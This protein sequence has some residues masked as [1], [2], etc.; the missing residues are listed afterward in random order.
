MAKKKKTQ[1]S[2]PVETYPV[3]EEILTTFI[4]AWFDDDFETAYELLS[5][6]SP[7]REGLDLDE[8]VE[9]RENWAEEAEPV[10]LEPG[11]ISVRQSQQSEIWV[12]SNVS[13]APE[14]K[15][16]EAAWSVE[17]DDTDLDETLPELPQ[18]T[19]VYDETQ[20]H[21]YWATYTLV[22]E[23]G[24]WR[25]ES[26][27]DETANARSL[28]VE[29]LQQ[30]I[31][32][33]D[34]YVNDFQ[35]KYSREA[36][37]EFSEE[38]S[39]YFAGEIFKRLLQAAAYTDALIEKTPLVRELY[40]SAAA[41]MV[42]FDQL[43]RCLVYLEPLT[44]QFE[45]GRAENLR[46]MADVQQMLSEKYAEVGE[47][48]REIR[49]DELAEE[50]LK[51]SLTI[52]E[53]FEA[54]IALAELYIEQDG[55][56]EAK[57]QLLQAQTLISNPAEEAHVEVHLGE[58]ASGQDEYEEALRHYQRVTELQ[59]E[60]PDSWSDLAGAYEH[61]DNLELAEANYRHAIELETGDS[62]DYYYNLSNMYAQQGDRE[63]AAKIIQEGLKANPA[64]AP[65]YAYLAS[66]AMEDGEYSQAETLLDK[67]ESLDPE[68]EIIPLFRYTLNIM[69]M[70]QAATARKA[71]K[72][73][74]PTNKPAKKKK[75]R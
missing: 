12:P 55:L 25:I 51:E 33:I 23:E 53:N 10:D 22:Q 27:V 16:I 9:R 69:K 13:R 43:E 74:K 39:Q 48:E 49:F 14:Q 15:L 30:R 35:A 41:R 38:E 37:A 72:P 29:A 56:D 57:E 50:S 32:E 11:F 8:W 19:A 71:S 63:Q 2:A 66:M 67:A 75:K 36:I 44:Q 20:R 62:T 34:Q 7:L 52:E 73:S 42:I 46:R 59:P 31:G 70:Q 1:N 47:D 54:R 17:L 28:S 4:E 18:A 45:E 58:V 24:E 26:L 6:T 65:L 64:S 60:Q 61:L 21:W 3:P 5:S 40:E 68:L